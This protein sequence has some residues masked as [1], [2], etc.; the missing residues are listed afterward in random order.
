MQRSRSRAEHG[1]CRE[2]ECG[3]GTNWS[4]RWEGSRAGP[5]RGY[6]HA[7]RPCSTC[8]LREDMQVSATEASGQLH[9]QLWGVGRPPH[10]GAIFIN[11][12]GPRAP[13][14][15]I[16]DR[17]YLERNHGLDPQGAGQRAGAAAGECWALPPEGLGPQSLHLRCR[18]LHPPP[19]VPSTTS[20][21][22][23]R[24]RSHRRA[25]P[26]LGFQAP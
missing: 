12:G 6:A 9:A 16:K 1:V 8:V 13:Q 24:P 10:P 20:R 21:S 15:R 23:T 19:T 22:G 2:L 17:L 4:T 18:P 5:H 11:T 26:Q 14:W 25:Q 3:P 7:H